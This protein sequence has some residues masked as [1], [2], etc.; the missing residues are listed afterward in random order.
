MNL[1]GQ[2]INGMRIVGDPTR[3]GVRGSIYR[4]PCECVLCGT[5]K[6]LTLQS[7]RKRKMYGCGCSVDGLITKNGISFAEWCI[8]NNNKQLL[9]LWDDELN[10]PQTSFTSRFIAKF[11]PETKQNRWYYELMTI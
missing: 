6:N 9:D 5:P 7:L 3:S 1:I 10:N 4:Y 2:I 11:A 8:Q